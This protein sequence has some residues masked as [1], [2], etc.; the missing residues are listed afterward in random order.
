[1]NNRRLRSRLDLDRNMLWLLRACAAACL[2][3]G[4]LFGVVMVGGTPAPELSPDHHENA[5]SELLQMVLFA[6][7]FGNLMLGLAYGR[8]GI[9]W[10]IGLGVLGSIVIVAANAAM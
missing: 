3:A 9:L 10:G 7:V 6:L 4:A 1:M 2:L 8:R 5:G